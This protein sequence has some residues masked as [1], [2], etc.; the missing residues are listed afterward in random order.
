MLKGNAEVHT[1][2]MFVTGTKSC[3]LGVE[4]LIRTWEAEVSV[5]YK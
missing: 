5:W 2:A 4:S 1:G 3:L